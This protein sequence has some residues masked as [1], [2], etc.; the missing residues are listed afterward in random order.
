MRLVGKIIKHTVRWL[1]ISAVL[2]ILITVG[3]YFFIR[4]SVD[5]SRDEALFSLSKS[6]SVTHFYANSSYGGAYVPVEVDA[7]AFGEAR[8]VW[9]GSC[10]ISDYIKDGFV[11]TEDRE[12]Y[13]HGGVN[14]RRTVGAVLSYFTGGERYGASTITQQ[15]I[16]N[17]SGDN[18]LTPM[19]K[20]REIVRALELEK[21]HTKDEILEM[22]I[23]IAPMSENIA[24]VGYASDRLFGKEPSEL[25]LAEAATLVGLTNSPARYDPRKN[26][27]ACRK[28]RDHVLNAMLDCGFITEQEFISAVNE[29]ITLTDRDDPETRSWFVET[30]L[31]DVTRDLAKKEGISLSAASIKIMKG[32]Y[33]IYMTEISAVQSALEEYFGDPGNLPNELE[34]GLGVAMCVCDSETGELV[35]II[36]S[37]GK[38]SASGLLNLATVPHPPGSTLKPLALYAPLIDLGSVRWSTIF[39]DSPVEYIIKD[40]EEVAY[41]KNSPDRYDGPISVENA[42]KLSKNTVAIRLYGLL[43]ARRIFTFLEDEFGFDTLVSR[44][45][46]T[47]GRV[48]TDLASAPLALGQLTEGVTLRALTEA[49][50]VFPSEGI[51]HSPRSYV[52]VT[53]KNGNTVLEAEAGGRRVFSKEGARLMNQLLMNVVADGTAKRITLKHTVDTAGKTGTSSAERDKLFVGYTPYFT[54]GIWCGYPSGRESVGSISPSHLQMWDEVMVKLHDGVG[55]ERHFS[56]D[57]LLRGEFC[58]DSGLLPT[59][60]CLLDPRADRISHG[61]FLPG[62]LPGEY[63]EHGKNGA[64]DERMD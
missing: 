39:D 43:G 64:E 22:Y 23:N 58:L 11:A 47:S 56:T 32:G 30:A 25:T 33:N 49:Y 40:G 44:K 20:A 2:L 15:V 1:V 50:T 51:K 24:G 55:S 60:D 54:A 12:F 9:Y 52:T 46:D 63:C 45:T 27:D 59:D 41:P 53:D 8:R 34:S 57:G 37:A 36:G 21:N 5:T 14:F 31:A 38:K 28:R 3:A 16:K 7:T 13:N 18:Y 62:T 29:P 6:S 4:G 26:P 42:L 35:G 19:R 48:L 61:F 17:I 10:E